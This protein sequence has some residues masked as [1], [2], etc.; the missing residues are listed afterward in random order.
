MIGA[1]GFRNERK[2]SDGY[3]SAT[4]RREHEQCL[5]GGAGVYYAEGYRRKDR[6]GGFDLAPGRSDQASA[7]CEH[8]A[9][10]L[11]EK[12]YHLQA[13]EGQATESGQ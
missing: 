10:I 1:E 7:R 12:G 2:L 13:I 4:M 6:T 3:W 5:V 8:V 9:S 11:N